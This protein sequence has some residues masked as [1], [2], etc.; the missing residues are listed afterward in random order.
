MDWKAC[1]F[2]AI[3]VALGSLVS[4]FIFRKKPWRERLSR[5]P[6]FLTCA[7]PFF[8]IGI[9]NLPVAL[10]PVFTR[11]VGHS[12]W[13]MYHF[14]KSA[15]GIEHSETWWVARWLSPVQTV[16]LILLP[17][18]IVWALVNAIRGHQ[19]KANAVGAVVGIVLVLV[20]VYLTAAF[21]LF[22]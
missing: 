17:I 8:Y 4:F 12:I 11:I 18:G 16:F 3:F 19:P 7:L 9:A 2:S 14:P 5:V 21:G 1:L 6:L 13:A 22:F 15:N 10:Q 20:S